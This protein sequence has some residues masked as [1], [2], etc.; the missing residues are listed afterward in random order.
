M[1][2]L[3]VVIATFNRLEL[4]KQ[5]IETAKKNADNKLEI[6]VVDDASNDGTKEYLK[7][8]DFI[9]YYRFKEH[10]YIAG[11]KNKGIEMASPSK[12]IY[13]SDNDIYFLPHWDSIMIKAL[14]TYSDVG[15]VG[16]RKHPHHRILTD[17]A[18]SLRRID[19]ITVCLVDNQA[20]YSF[21][22]RRKDLDEVGY[23]NDTIQ[24][25]IR[26]GEDNDFIERMK[27]KG[28]IVACVDPPVLYHCGLYSF[29]GNPTSDYP[30]MINLQYSHSE[31]LF[32]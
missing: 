11:V 24:A 32:K 17:R 22:L 16:G 28:K 4:L 20:G 15:I 26:G 19:N 30:E 27:S 31:I 7:S 29:T 5:T 1:D 21:M 12:Y 14:E 6:I 10:A 25:G 9:K 3:P 23:F 2:T 8:L 18:D 13:I